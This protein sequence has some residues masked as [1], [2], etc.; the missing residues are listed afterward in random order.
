MTVQAVPAYK[1]GKW[2]GWTRVGRGSKAFVFS[3]GG[4]LMRSNSV[5]PVRATLAISARY[6][7]RQGGLRAS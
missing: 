2:P 1:K 6:L 3:T 5:W 4:G 7:V